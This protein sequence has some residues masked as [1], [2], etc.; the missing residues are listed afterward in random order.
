MIMRP[1]QALLLPA[2]ATFIWGSMVV[3]FLL[4]VFLN[5]SMESS[6]QWLPDFLAMTL[7]F[8]NL[9]QTRR[10]GLAAAFAFGL[11]MDVHQS[12][13]LGQHALAY[14]VM[15]YFAVTLHRRLAFFS[16]SEQALQLI[17][18]FV[19]GHALQWLVR[20]VADG[21]WPQWPALIAPLC[22]LLLWPTLAYVLLAPQRRAP[23][24]DNNR[25]L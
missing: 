25:P 24:P 19:G 18:L 7:V 8:W 14:S 23:D 17:P 10:V 3:A 1:G 21:S 6:G 12:A 9:N 2:S 16:A 13:L 20:W 5:L 22:D 11:M 4:N 15:A